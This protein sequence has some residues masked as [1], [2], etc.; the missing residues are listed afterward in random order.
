MSHAR[1][2]YDGTT[3]VPLDPLDIPIGTIVTFD[4]DIGQAHGDSLPEMTE[5][6]LLQ[7]ARE[8]GVESPLSDSQRQMLRYFRWHDS[9]DWPSAPTLPLEAYDRESLYP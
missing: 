2:R 7:A 1:A 4:L 3:L 8:Y 9:Q 6:E 5:E